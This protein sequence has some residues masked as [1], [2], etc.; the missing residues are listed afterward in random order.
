MPFESTFS[1][2]LSLSSRRQRLDKTDYSKTEDCPIPSFYISLWNNFFDYFLFFFS[3]KPEAL[4]DRIESCLIFRTY[5]LCLFVLNF[6][7]SFT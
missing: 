1:F 7:N 5:V 2:F 4:I 6:I 3:K